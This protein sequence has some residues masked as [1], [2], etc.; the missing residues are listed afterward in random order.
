MALKLI[1]W[2]WQTT[3]SL[4][5][6]TVKLFKTVIVTIFEVLLIGILEMFMI[7]H[8]KMKHSLVLY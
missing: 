4:P 8:L 5:A 2:P 6:C 1:V 7:E 3:I